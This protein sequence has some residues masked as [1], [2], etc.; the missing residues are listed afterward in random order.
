MPGCGLPISPSTKRKWSFT[1]PPPSL[2]GQA[3]LRVQESCVRASQAALHLFRNTH[4][5]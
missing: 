5:W 1:D 4:C 3:Y 2:V